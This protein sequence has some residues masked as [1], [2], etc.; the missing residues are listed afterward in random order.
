MTTTKL[1][2]PIII[3]GTGRCGSTVFH[4]LLAKHPGVMWL[5]PSLAPE[6]AE[7]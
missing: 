2:K 5:S 3:V 1:T 6:R 7:T 4:R